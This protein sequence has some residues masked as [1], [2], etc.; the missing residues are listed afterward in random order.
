MTPDPRLLADLRRAEGCS[1]TAYRD[2]L[3]NWTIGYGHLLPDPPPWTSISQDTANTLLAQDVAARCAQ[4][5]TLP[6]WSSLDTPCRQNAVIECVFN[7]G[8]GHW[9]REF[10]G[11]R[12]ALISQDWQAAHDKLL[13]SPLWIQQVGLGRVTRLA[14][15]LLNGQYPASI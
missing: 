13:Q 10:P 3:G 2:S 6:E 8:L 5:D 15:Y 11:T 14:Q 4:V 1:L 12:S 9:Q 7:L